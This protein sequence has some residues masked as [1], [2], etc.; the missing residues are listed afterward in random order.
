M[1]NFSSHLFHPP[2]AIVVALD[3]TDVHILLCCLLCGAKSHNAIII[4]VAKLS[5]I[6]IIFLSLFSPAHITETHALIHFQRWLKSVS[7][8][9]LSTIHRLHNMNGILWSERNQSK[10]LFYFQNN[11]K[12][13]VL[14]SMYWNSLFLAMVC[15]DVGYN[16]GA[17]SA[18]ITAITITA[19]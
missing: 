15:V 2:T 1:K 16:F 19:D 13:V 12:S 9:L 17:N 5:I 11:A 6:I 14:S 7:L 8:V 18:I 3:Q 4:I 10:Y